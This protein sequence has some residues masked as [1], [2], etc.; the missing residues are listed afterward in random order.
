MGSKGQT[1]SIDVLIAIAVFLIV[2]AFFLVIGTNLFPE[3]RNLDLEAE[4]LASAVST[5]TSSSPAL[6]EGAKVSEEAISEFLVK[7]YE[8]LKI[9]LGMQADFCIYFEDD[10][11]NVIF[12]SNG[13]GSNLEVY[14]IGSEEISVAGTPCRTLNSS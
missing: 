5:S 4:K 12:L 7:R 10:E 9:D 3:T 13:T 11:G 2:I 6:I 14:G 8:D 1:I